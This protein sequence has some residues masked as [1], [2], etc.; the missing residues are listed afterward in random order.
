[1]EGGFVTD[2]DALRIP[3]A[4]RA[5]AV[6]V[7]ALTDE[8]CA[9]HLDEEY[10]ELC[11]RVVGKLARK[12]PSPLERGDLRIWAAGVVYALAQVNFLFD[13]AQNPHLTA[14]VLSELLGVKKTTMAN[15]GRMIRD[16]IGLDHFDADYLRR[17]LVAGSSLVWMLEVD[18]LIVD[19]RQL[20][21]DLQ[22]EAHRRGLIPYVP[23][24]EADR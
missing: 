9:S 12:R 10:A 7:L 14:D 24:V 22:M 11:G 1:M 16:L 13:R 19:A 8:F 18:G 17:D 20:P 2:L 15:K 5:T 21:I 3:Q 6:Q 4:A 23:A